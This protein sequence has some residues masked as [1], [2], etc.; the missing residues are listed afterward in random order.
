MAAPLAHIAVSTYRHAKTPLQRQLIIGFGIV[1]ASVMSVGMRLY[2]M[3]HAGYPGGDMSADVIRQ[4][5]HTVVEQDAAAKTQPT[6]LQILR[7]AA[8]GFG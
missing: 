7:E 2:L 4:R 5:T 1:G 6:T 8:K 3:C